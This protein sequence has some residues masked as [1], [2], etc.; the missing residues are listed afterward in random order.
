MAQSRVLKAKPVEVSK[1]VRTAA[2][3]FEEGC[4]K[5][6][7]S[8]LEKKRDELRAGGRALKPVELKAAADELEEIQRKL[9]PLQERHDELSER[10]LV[11]W[12]YTGIEEIE[13]DLGNTLIAPSFKLQLDPDA[14]RGGVG[15]SWAKATE[16]RLSPPLL[17]SLAEKD[18]TVRQ[19]A[20]RAARASVSVKIIPPSSRRPRSGQTDVEEDEE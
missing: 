20:I 4:K 6:K 10:L 14:V 13:G 8:A 12:A 19:I 15:E 16:R 17:F 11:H 3:W 5:A 1:K 18:E 9:N 7:E 2:P